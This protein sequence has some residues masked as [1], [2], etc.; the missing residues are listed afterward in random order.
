M[1]KTDKELLE[2]AAKA[3]GIEGSY[4]HSD[5]PIHCGIYQARGQYYWNPLASD[6]E[7]LRLALTLV[8]A[9]KLRVQLTNA[10]ID[11]WYLDDGFWVP[12]TWG[13]AEPKAFNKCVVC[14]AANYQEAADRAAASIGE[15]K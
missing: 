9:G 8:A 3:A 15:K 10:G 6:S 7:A 5:N 2:L 13:L 1:S 4:F 14:A 11:V 12:C